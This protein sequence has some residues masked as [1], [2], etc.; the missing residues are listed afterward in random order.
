MEEPETA[1]AA[2]GDRPGST[3]NR[4]EQ[5]PAQRRAPSATAGKTFR[6][7]TASL[8]YR[9]VFLLALTAAGLF[10][11]FLLVPMGLRTKDWVMLALLGMWAAA[12]LRYWAFLLA[13]PLRIRCEE[14]GHLNVQ[15]LFRT[16]RI[17]CGEVSAL[18]VSTLYP[19]YLKIQTSRR[20]SLLLLNHIDGL[21]ELILTIRSR[22]PELTTRGC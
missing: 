10:L 22:N 18:Q 2:P 20:K 16:V 7:S 12:L 17:P 4:G 19:S 1:T 21:H 8:V 5:D 3:E 14:D 15:S 6:V 11:L 9:L 13:M